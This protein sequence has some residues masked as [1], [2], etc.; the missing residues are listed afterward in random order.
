MVGMRASSRF[1]I[2]VTLVAV[3]FASTGGC[4]GGDS[5][6][7]GASG[8]GG[9]GGGQG[10][11]TI[12]HKGTSGVAVQGTLLTSTQ[13]LQGEVFIGADGKI[14]CAAASCSSTSGYAD[15]TV[16]ACPDAVVS[17]GLINAHDHTDFAT[18]GPIK[19]GST[20][21]QHRN[22]WRKGT[23]GGPKLTEPGFADDARTNAS[24]E[25]RFVLGGATSV[26]GSGGTRGLL[27]NL[28]SYPDTSLLEGA[29]GAST[30]FDTFPLGDQDGTELTSGCAYPSP[31]SPGS[32]FGTAPAYV[33]HVAEGI[34][35]AAENEF[36][37]VAGSLG[38]LTDK[39]SIIHGV[40]M[41]AAD[42]KKVAD[43]HARLIW[44]PRTNISLY[45]NTATVTAFKALG[46]T[47]A[48]GTDWLASGSMNMLR[49]L[50]CADSLNQKYFGKA[51]SDQEL[52]LMA[53][54]NAAI[55]AGFETQLGDLAPG[56]LG[57]VAVFA[58]ATKDHRAVIDAG[59]ED[60]HLVLRG[61]KVLYGDEEVVRALDPTCQPF[62]ACGQKKLVCM[63]AGLNLSEVEATATGIYPLFFCKDQ[64]PDDEPTCEPYRTEYANGIT[65]SDADGDG[66]P[67]A[68]DSCPSVFNPARPMDA[69]GQADVDGDGQGDACDASP[70][71]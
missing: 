42:I 35:V 51:F 37:C 3:A 69:S 9:A 48:L 15:A 29:T 17:P 64:T 31:R 39:T 4:R 36:A 7:G 38:L 65:A 10:V 45:G 22:G 30:F 32:A 56:L 49:E 26:V 53:T 5:G 44:S 50:K 34:N 47:I 8:G 14:A 59:V 20:R 43:A 63:E 61:G 21:W 28:A 19:H 24:A 40:G 57:D 46:V 70:A 66:V 41:N 54:K 18:E 58:G 52:W 23:N 71:G 13:I 16:V 62:D 67:D 68:T 27:R 1:Q 25:L 33:P 6:S 55:A 60:V 2:L 12:K 11:C